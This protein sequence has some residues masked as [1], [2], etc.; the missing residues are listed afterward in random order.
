[1]F[2]SDNIGGDGKVWNIYYCSQK[3]DKLKLLAEMYPINQA[4]RKRTT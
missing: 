4:K 1:M 2:C 3:H